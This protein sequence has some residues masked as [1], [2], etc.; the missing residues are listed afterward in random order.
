MK[1]KRGRRWAFCEGKRIEADVQT[2]MQNVTI[3]VKL[4]GIRRMRWGMRVL[5]WALYAAAWMIGCNIE[6]DL[7]YEGAG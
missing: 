2:L 1:R 4:K 3:K 7:E 6:T 5:G